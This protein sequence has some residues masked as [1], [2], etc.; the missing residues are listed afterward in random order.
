MARLTDRAIRALKA[1]ATAY[2]RKDS[3]VRGMRVRV[4]PSGQKTFVLLAR[5]PG[6]N[7][8][9]TRRAL[10]GYDE[11]TLEEA[12][13]K[14]RNW[15]QLIKRGV[16]PAAEERR[17]RIEKERQQENTFAA[18]TEAFFR[19]GLRG[20][21]R[22][23]E[24]MR[25]VRKVFI[26]EAKWGPRPIH[27]ITALDVRAVVRGYGDHGKIHHAHNLLGYLRR[28]YNWAIAQEIYGLETS[29]C[30]RVK[31]NAVI[32]R[33]NIRTR[34]LSD[35]EIRAAW[36]AADKFGYP[37]GPLFRLLMLLGQRRSEVGGIRWSEL[38]L[39]E[40]LWVIPAER[41]KAAA[42][43]VV[44]LPDDAVTILAA[45]PRFE[46]DFVFTTNGGRT[47]VFGYSKYKKILDARILE[48][49][50]EE[51][52]KAKLSNF[53]IHDFR[54]TMRTRLSAIPNISDLVR[55]LVIG[56]TRPGLHRVYDQHAYQAE[57]RHALES[58]AA[59]LRAIVNPPPANVVEL[60]S[61]Q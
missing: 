55:E 22:G 7:P 19:E 5:Y 24:V 17:A 20:Q 37:W 54:R 42:A 53:V 14:A 59:K 2:D 15:R 41:M 8:H 50:R 13:E 6:A 3:E 25:D 61:A 18:V 30:D 38:D 23:H 32:G 11:L 44:P 36:I 60:R 10:G 46:G 9:P 43:H 33:K 16:D 27:E 31:A 39:S 26:D 56:H 29:P 35:S 48:V 57:K 4:L 49:L 21:R 52:P 34:V 40:R 28:F 51:D 47:P 58:W 45:L 12:R 1:A